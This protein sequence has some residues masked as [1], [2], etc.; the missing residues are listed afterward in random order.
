MCSQ[1]QLSL[2]IQQS[3]N[4]TIQQSNN[5]TI[6][7]SNNPTIQQSNNPTIQQS[8]NPTIQ[9]SNTAEGS[10]AGNPTPPKCTRKHMLAA[11]LPKIIF[12]PDSCYPL[13][14]SA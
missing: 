11:F 12:F 14:F 8:N 7:Q 3:N 10:T 1:F 9:Q 5:P 2:T 4:P 13:R 6:Q